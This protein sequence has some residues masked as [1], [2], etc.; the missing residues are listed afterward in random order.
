M[1]AGRISRHPGITKAREQHKEI[2]VPIYEY[3]CS[4][5]KHHFEQLIRNP[6]NASNVACPECGST[7]TARTLSVFAVNSGS[8]PQAYIP[9][10]ND[11]PTCG[12][13][14]GPP[15]SCSR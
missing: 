15:G 9:N 7:K 11:A 12:H 14:G 5:C 1:G 2:D 4:S 10:R 6:A 3:S 8:E 13:C